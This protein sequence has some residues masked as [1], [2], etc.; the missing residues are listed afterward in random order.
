MK[1]NLLNSYLAVQDLRDKEA[2]RWSKAQ[3]Q[4]VRSRKIYTIEAKMHPSP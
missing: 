3:L 4:S 2:G 1:Q